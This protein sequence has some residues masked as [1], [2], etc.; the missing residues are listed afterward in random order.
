MSPPAAF[1]P[2]LLDA[3]A[4]RPPHNYFHGIL[5]DNLCWPDNVILFLRRDREALNPRNFESRPHHRHVLVINLAATGSV[6][7]D[8]A[9]FHLHPGEAFLIAPF[10]V[11]IYMEIERR[12]I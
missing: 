4:A 12:E 2:A 5:A 6:S 7:V 8:G 1:D 11:H 9:A 10:Q 3:L